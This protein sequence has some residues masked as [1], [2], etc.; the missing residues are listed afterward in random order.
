MKFG[1]RLRLLLR[2][3][4]RVINF[5]KKALMDR[6][7]ELGEENEK[8]VFNLRSQLVIDGKLYIIERHF[9]DNRNVREAVFTAVKN[10]AERLAP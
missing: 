6:K 2:H 8:E 4:S 9:S 7:G 5:L 1:Q 10:E 3:I